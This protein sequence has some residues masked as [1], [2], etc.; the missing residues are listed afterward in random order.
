MRTEN[1]DIGNLIKEIEHVRDS[2]K[3]EQ[4]GEGFRVQT[5]LGFFE[6]YADSLVVLLD[7]LLHLRESTGNSGGTHRVLV[8]GFSSDDAASAFS[9]ALAKAAHYFSEQ[10]DV[11]VSLQKLTEIPKG[12]Y[13]A[14]MEVHMT[15]VVLKDRF[16]IVD[17]DVELKRIHDHSYAHDRKDEAAALK[18][19]VFDHF[20]SKSGGV[21]LPD[22][23][24]INIQDAHL[25]EYM[26]EKQF[27]EVGH[28][29]HKP[30]DA[31]KGLSAKHVIVRKRHHDGERE[32]D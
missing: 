20:T 11:S 1:I 23:F 29:M 12:G 17:A 8:E 28:K 2:V 27:F 31:A 16:D 4:L 5:A 22:H 32:P 15:P 24:L 6:R 25:L 21:Q 7:E 3:S 19:L 14:V 9:D 18:H 10:H 13:H 30:E 26:I